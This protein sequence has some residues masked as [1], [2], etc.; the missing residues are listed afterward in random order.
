MSRTDQMNDFDQRAVA[1]AEADLARLL[2][3]EPSPEFAAKVRVRIAA[4]PPACGWNWG[5]LLVP[6]AA[7][8][9]AVIGLVLSGQWSGRSPEQ[10]LATSRQNDIVLPATTANAPFADVPVVA[11]VAQSRPTVQRA[12]ASPQREPEVIID[13]AIS[14]TIRRLALAARSTVLDGSKGESIAAPNAEFETL[15]IAEPLNVPELVLKPAD[16]TGGQ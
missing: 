13:P 2:S 12:I 3:I 10:P 11:A 6:L 8:A 1:A 9:V 4:E 14:D 7:A 5:R 15:P 16:Q